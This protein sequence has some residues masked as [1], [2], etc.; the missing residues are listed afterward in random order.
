[1]F[2][3]G[4]PESAQAISAR[5]GAK[6]A[7]D[8]QRPSVFVRVNGRSA[9]DILAMCERRQLITALSGGSSSSCP[10]PRA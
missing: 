2:K 7:G 5:E 3:D 4:D 9:S 6:V 1:M 8:A 10:L